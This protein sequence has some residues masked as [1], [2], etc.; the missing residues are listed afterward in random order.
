MRK[1]GI[2]KTRIL[3]F[4][5]VETSIETCCLAPHFWQQLASEEIVK[6][7]GIARSWFGEYALINQMFNRFAL[8]FG[9]SVMSVDR[10]PA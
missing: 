8:H 4:K 1:I 9:V 5:T 2:I 7:L 6:V 10:R 3:S